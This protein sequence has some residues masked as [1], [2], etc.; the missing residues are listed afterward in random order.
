[1]FVGR[2]HSHDRL[3]LFHS[4]DLMDGWIE[5]PQS[6]LIV[7]DPEIARPGGPVVSFEGN[8]YRL[9]QDCSPRYG[10]QLRAFRITS[11]SATEYAEEPIDDP[12]LTAGES[13]WNA[14]GMHHNDPHRMPDGSWRAAVDG[15]SKLWKWR[16]TP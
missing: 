9:A 10:N 13:G 12:I 3:Q 2:S 1:M 6:P 16:S 4:D 15:H 14:T 11:L 8:L 7:D 5:H